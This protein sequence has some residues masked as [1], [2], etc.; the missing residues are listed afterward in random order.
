[1]KFL[2]YGYGDVVQ[3]RME[4]ALKK[5]GIKFAI[6]EVDEAN[7]EKARQKGITAYKYGE[8]DPYIKQFNA[9][10][11]AT[12]PDRHFEPFRKAIDNSVPV[13]VEKPL[14]HDLE[15]AKKMRNMAEGRRLVCMAIDHYVLKFFENTSARKDHPVFISDDRD[16]GLKAVGKDMPP[17]PDYGW[18][19]RIVR[20][21][22]TRS[23]VLM[24]RNLLSMLNE[25]IME[26]GIRY[27]GILPGGGYE[28]L[29]R[30]AHHDLEELYNLRAIRYPIWRMTMLD[31]IDRLGVDELY[32]NLKDRLDVLDK[33][34]TV[35]SH[36]RLQLLFLILTLVTIFISTSALILQEIVES[37]VAAGFPLVLA[38]FTAFFL[39]ALAII[40][41]YYAIYALTSRIR[42]RT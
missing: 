23:L 17:M 20:N 34:I 22:V 12:P 5:L 29:L 21:L 8:E 6:V 31:T 3:N 16:L 27:R 24:L 10:I 37:L 7:M 35:A 9:V 32:E 13:M 26:R 11:I 41:I 38:S 30:R 18:V 4:K 19:N 42:V 14:A 15:T 39:T 36:R 2:I 25:E 1:M 40:V 28:D 33:F